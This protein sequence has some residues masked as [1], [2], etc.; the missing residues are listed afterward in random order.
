MR[1]GELPPNYE[2]YDR[3]RLARLCKY[4]Q[5][6][7]PEAYAGYSILIFRLTAEDLRAA[8]DAPVTGTHRM[9]LP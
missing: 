6:R 7:P 3:L 9:R 1:H 2:V 4:L 5:A 8:L